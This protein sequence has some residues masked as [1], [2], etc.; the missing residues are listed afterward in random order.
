VE[1]EE[2][3]HRRLSATSQQPPCLALFDEELRALRRRSVQA[4]HLLGRHRLAA[5][6]PLRRPP[7]VPLQK[8]GDIFYKNWGIQIGAGGQL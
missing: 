4:L 5:L 8:M 2:D 3:I 1:E 6:H 7:P